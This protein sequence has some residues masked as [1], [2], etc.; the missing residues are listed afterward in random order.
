MVVGLD[1][2]G[3]AAVLGVILEFEVID[4]F[5]KVCVEL[6]VCS[7]IFSGNCREWVIGE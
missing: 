4:R 1:V 2:V 6:V 5:S 7:V 3:D